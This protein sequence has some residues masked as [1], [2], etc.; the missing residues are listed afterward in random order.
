MS[1]A[2]LPVETSAS[3]S[4]RCRVREA[5][6]SWADFCNVYQAVKTHERDRRERPNEIRAMAWAML[7]SPG[8]WSFWRCGF[9]NRY[10]AA[11]E[12]Y[13]LT[14]IPGYDEIGRVI[15]L[16]FPE[17][18]DDEGTERLFDFLMAPYDKMPGRDEL[19]ELTLGDESWRT[20]SQ[21]AA[22]CEVGAF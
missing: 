4:L 12:Q 19:I 13:D 1:T 5:G 18:G 15:G 16:Q 21:P 9:Q 7:S 6:Y 3:Q 22:Q 10:G 20:A 2:T 17:Y 8:C 14:V 11:V